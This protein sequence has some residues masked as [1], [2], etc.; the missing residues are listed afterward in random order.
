MGCGAIFNIHECQIGG[1]LREHAAEFDELSGVTVFGEPVEKRIS[2]DREAEKE[3]ISKGIARDFAM[4]M[5]KRFDGELARR[6]LKDHG[7]VRTVCADIGAIVSDPMSERTVSE[8][9]AEDIKVRLKERIERAEKERKPENV[10]GM[11]SVE[12]RGA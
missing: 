9:F 1:E 12:T 3:C 10:G 4:G 2:E 7:K 11:R 5:V 6:K 8:T